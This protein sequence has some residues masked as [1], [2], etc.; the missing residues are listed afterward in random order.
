M[1][2]LRSDTVT[3][4]TPAMRH[5]MAN[6]EVGDDVF[7]ED[8][9]VHGLED[10]L[11]GMLG[12]EAGV[13][14]PSG[15]MTNQIAIHLHTRAGDEVIC[16]EGAHFYRYEGGGVMANSGASV[17]LIP[18]DRGRFTADQVRSAINDPKAEWLARTS[19]VSLEN[20]CNRGGGA[21]WDLNE[22]KAIRKLCKSHGLAIHLDGARLFNALAATQEAPDAWGRE[23]DTVSICLSKGLGAP[24][25]SVLVGSKELVAEA[26]RVR[27]R[28]GG[29]MRQV[30]VLAAAGLHA[31]RHHRARIDEDHVRAHRLRTVL[32]GLD[33]V[34][35]VMPVDTNIIIYELREDHAADV[36]VAELK[37]NGVLCMAISSHQVRMVTHLDI[38]DADI[39]HTMHV[40]Q[41]RGS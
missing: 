33:H 13:F 10:E 32:E 41:R 12:H 40:L 14:C 16:E 23:F 9:T 39:E 6:A 38:T 3:R 31:I 11:A 2:D 26:R 17:K 8:P 22:V 28:L 15:T 20:T 18:G 24:V 35:R 1:I 29:G 36:H 19:L 21:V 4:P 5:A 30:G 7:G 27:K 34:Q 25:G 37:A